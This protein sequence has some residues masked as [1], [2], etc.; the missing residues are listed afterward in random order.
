MFIPI[1]DDIN[2]DNDENSHKTSFLWTY[3]LYVKDVILHFML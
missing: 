3:D 2:D 1:I